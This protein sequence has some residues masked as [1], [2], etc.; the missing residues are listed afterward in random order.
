MPGTNI[1]FAWVL[2]CARLSSIQMRVLANATLWRD[3]QL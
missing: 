2:P 3:P 1:W